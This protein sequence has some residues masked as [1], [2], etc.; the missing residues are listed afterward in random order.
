MIKKLI[1]C[2]GVETILKVE[3]HDLMSLNKVGGQ[4]ALEPLLIRVGYSMIL[5][6]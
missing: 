5:M 2:R 6:R 4:G 1:N 3:G